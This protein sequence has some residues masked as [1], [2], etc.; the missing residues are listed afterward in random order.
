MIWINILAILL[1]TVYLFFIVYQLL[2]FYYMVNPY[3]ACLLSSNTER[4]APTILTTC[5]KYFDKLSYTN[6]IELG[7][8]KANI[9]RYMSKN[10][11]FNSVI[12]VEGDLITYFL[13]YGMSKLGK[14]KNLHLIKNDILKYKLPEGQNIIYVYL[15]PKLIKKMYE[16]GI[17]KNQLVISLTFSIDHQ[18]VK[19]VEIIK[20]GNFQKELYVYDF[21]IL[22]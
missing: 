17:F 15:F 4:I 16:R 6:F 21:R 12:G 9:S 18:D 13:S 19:P 2:Q 3:K 20:V 5:Q 11:T 7:S 22:E 10:G 8:G 1:I 14:Y